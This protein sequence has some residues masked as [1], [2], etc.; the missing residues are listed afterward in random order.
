MI[1]VIRLEPRNAISTPKALAALRRK[2]LIEQRSYFEK[3][4]SHLFQNSPQLRWANIW[5]GCGLGRISSNNFCPGSGNTRR[6]FAARFALAKQLL[7]ST[8]RVAFLIKVASDPP[9]QIKILRAVITASAAALHRLDF[10]KFGFPKA[11]DMRWQ[12]QLLHDFADRTKRG[13]GFGGVPRRLRL[14]HRGHLRPPTP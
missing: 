6:C 14:A 7:N 4:S 11:Q 1:I 12:I 3:L 5:I 8:D 13:L 9:Q 10:R 2:Q